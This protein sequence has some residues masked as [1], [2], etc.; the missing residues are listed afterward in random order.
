MQA[1]I[2]EKA[3]FSVIGREGTTDMGAG[4][5]QKLWQEANS[6]FDEVEKLAKRNEN[7]VPVGCWGAMSDLAL[8]FDPW[9]DDFS[10]GRYLAGVE[11]IDGAEPPEGWVKWTLPAFRFV[12]ITCD[13]G[14]TFRAG[15]AYLESQNMQLA[16]AVQD[17]TDPSTGESFMWF[18]IARL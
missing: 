9:S 1:V 2:V 18:P 14:D 5:V 8:H 12:R 7:G 13:G 11:C 6:R 10:Q 3:S 17:F 15:M 4:F 16:G